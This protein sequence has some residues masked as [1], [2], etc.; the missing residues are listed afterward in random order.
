VKLS[1]NYQVDK[2][3]TIALGYTYQCLHS[4]DYLYNAYQIGFTPSTLLPTNQQDQ[5]YSVNLLTATYTYN[6]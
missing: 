5:S 3:S 2:H 4:N 6:F 1:G